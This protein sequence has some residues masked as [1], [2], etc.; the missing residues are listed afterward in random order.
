[1]QLFAIATLISRLSLQCDNNV[2]RVTSTP[3]TLVSVLVQIYSLPG[4]Q[5]KTTIFD[6]NVE[7]HTGLAAIGLV[8]GEMR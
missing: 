3:A 7:T 8:R 1:M 5:G 6:R 2:T 4:P